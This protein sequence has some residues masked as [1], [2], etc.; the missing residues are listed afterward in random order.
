MIF[1]FDHG[2]IGTTL[3]HFV[4]L[5]RCSQDETELIVHG[6]GHTDLLTSG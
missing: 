1:E 4:V 6:I 3:Y 2:P 5:F